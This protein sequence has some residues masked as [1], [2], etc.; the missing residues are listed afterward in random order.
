MT[1]H[2]YYTRSNKSKIMVEYGA[3]NAA[4]RESL[5]QVQGKM[6]LFRGN[7]ETILEILQTQRAPASIA[8][9][10]THVAGVTN[11]T[12][13]SGTTFETS[14]ETV[15]PTTR[16]R[17]VV[18]ADSIR[19]VAAY[20][21]GMP[22]H[23]AAHLA[24]GGGG[25]IVPRELPTTSPPFNHSHNPNATHA[26]HAGYIGH[27][28]EDCWALKK[29][30]Q[31]LIDQEILSFSEENTNVKANP[32]P[33]H[34]GAAVNA[35]I[36]EENVES[37]L[38]AEEVKTT[39]S[40]VLQR[41]EQFGFLEGVHDDCA[42]CEFDPDNCDKL[43]DCVQELM[44]QGLIQ[45]SKSK[46][47]K[48]VVVI[49]PIM[50]VYR[51]KKNTKAVPWNYETTTYL[52]GKEIHIPDKEIVN[53]AG[54]GGM[55]RSGLDF[56]PK[57]TPRVS[58]APTVILPKEKVIP[59]PTPQAGAIVPATPSVTTAPVSTKVIDNK[60]AESETSKGKGPIVEKEQ[61][62]RKA[63]LK[64]LNAA[65]V[66][67]DITVDQFDEVVVNITAS[68]Y[69]GFNEAKLPPEGNAHNKALQIS[70]TYT[71]SLLSRVLVDTGS[72]LNVLPKSTLSEL[73]FKGAEMRT[74]TL[75]VRAF[76]G[77]RR[78]VIG[79][80]DLPICVGPHQF[81]ITFQIMDINPAYGC[82]FYRPWIHAAG[83]VTS[84]LQQRLK[85]LIDDKLVIVCGEEDLL[86]SELS[87]FRYV[88]TDEGIVEV[89]LH[90]LEFKEVSSATANHNQ[91][92][93]TIL[94]I[95]T[96]AKHT[97]EKGPLPNW[98]KVVNVAKKRDKFGISYH[99]AA[100]KASPK[101]KKF[102]LVKMSIL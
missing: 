50:I 60:A 69:L 95:V 49:E 57:Y 81:S 17:Q 99:P 87:S 73:Q 84:M 91:S 31:E 62:R 67:Q 28:T 78:Q 82:L 83:E 9:N 29:R 76:N 20:L 30:I 63:L 98:G 14:A 39:M 65:H 53:I 80:V 58:P 96:S 97:L 86:V 15:V 66:M 7:I 33:N 19:L 56:A 71:D 37:I 64:V 55:T 4:A 54:T 8:T 40:V 85:Y 21:R 38:R 32:L 52:G 68:R 93:A 101:K 92:S 51:K 102:N 89:P 24:N 5:A 1:H 44:D 23:F 48:E 59:T 42:V 27:S 79:E 72:S 61:A 43:R 47:A 36:E 70:V 75:I 2:Q 18:P 12:T 88:K 90:C 16:N 34:G 77:S 10:V 3:D 41:L 94:S 100:R 26:F 6:N 45:F 74:N 46:A 13:A 11:P 22:P 25:A 35:V